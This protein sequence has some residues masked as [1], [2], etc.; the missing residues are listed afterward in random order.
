MAGRAMTDALARPRPQIDHPEALQR[1][2]G[3]VVE[4]FEP[5]AIFLFGSRARCEAWDDSDYDLMVV[6]RDDF[7]AERLKYWEWGQELRGH[8]IDANLSFSRESAFAWRRHEVGTLEYE[9][10][11]DG[12]Q[13]YPKQRWLAASVERPGAMNATVVENWLREVED[14]LIAARKCCEGEDAVTGRSAFFVQQAAEKLTKAALVAHQDRPGRGHKI[15]E[16]TPR[17]PADF[18]LKER[19]RALERFSDFVW[20]WRYPGE[21]GQPPPPPQPEVAKVQAWIAEIEAL[22]AEFERWL[23]ARE[24]GGGA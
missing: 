16:F 1:V 8:G 10:E 12:I 21:E 22:K 19:F 11:V 3:W 14:D 6:L 9:V 20:V 15:Q 13:L 24:G 23:R 17:L 7:P 18:P 5:V 4:R 2:L